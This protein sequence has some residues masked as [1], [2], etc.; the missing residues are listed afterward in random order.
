MSEQKTNPELDTQEYEE[1]PEFSDQEL[2][3][4]IAYIE[5]SDIPVSV[6]N[7]TVKCLKCVSSINSILNRKRMSIRRLRRLFGFKTEKKTTLL[8]G[9]KV[10]PL[11]RR[12]RLLKMLTKKVTAET[13]TKTIPGPHKS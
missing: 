4:A 13:P 7:L 12:Q 9:E 3:E 10:L 8:K 11:S 2:S 1:T 6:R 5:A